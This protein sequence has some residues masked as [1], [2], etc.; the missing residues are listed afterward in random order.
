MFA[1]GQRMFVTRLLALE[2]R[3]ART[4]VRGA[5]T[6]SSLAAGGLGS[7][8]GGF[9]S[10]NRLEASAAALT[11]QHF[12]ITFC[13]LPCRDGGIGRR[14]RFRSWRWQHC[15]GSSPLLGRNPYPFWGYFWGYIC[16]PH[17]LPTLAIS[18]LAKK[19]AFSSRTRSKTPDNSFLCIPSPAQSLHRVEWM[20]QDDGFVAIGTGGNHIHRH[21][22]GLFD[23]L[24]IIT[25]IRGQLFV[26]GN[27]DGALRPA[28]NLLVNRFAA[29]QCVGAGRKNVDAFAAEVVTDTDLQRLNAIEHVQLGDA[30][31][32]HPVHRPGPLGRAGTHPAPPPRP[33]V[34]QPDSLPPG[35]QFFSYIV[36]QWG[37][38]RPHPSPCRVGLGE[39]DPVMQLW[40][41]A[42]APRRS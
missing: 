14:T 9:H 16:N 7:F 24:E 38:T 26:T 42:A 5:P 25:C 30:Q 27:S 20:A 34:P 3:I 17:W 8:L 39:P 12:P 32:R 33:P 19:F 15:G 2:K 18:A 40:G 21:A 10:D 23:A 31:T 37:R 36:V 1:A 29:G 22:A 6:R 35:P 28:R 4:D 11:R 41:A 13:A